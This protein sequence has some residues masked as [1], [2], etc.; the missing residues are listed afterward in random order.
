MVFEFRSQTTDLSAIRILGGEVLYRDMWTMYAPGSIYV[1]A[2]AYALFGVQMVVGNVLGILVSA[3][4]VAALYRLARLVAR[5]V[6]AA[7]VAAIFT[8][9]FLATNY[10]NSLASYP[11]AILFIFVGLERIA[12]HARSGA[13]R[14]LIVAG[15]SLGLGALF[16]HDIVAYACVATA[17]GLV[18]VPV[19]GR[20]EAVWS[21]LVLAGIVVGVM[22]VPLALLLAAGAGRAMVDQLITFPTTY[23]PVVRPEGF[24]VL[25]RLTTNLQVQWR[26]LDLN[27]PSLALLAGLPGVVTG[28]RK[29][30]PEARRVVVMAIFAFLFYWMAAHVQSNTHRVSM[31]AFGPLVGLA[32]LLRYG[33]GYPAPSRARTWALRLV[34]ALWCLAMLMPHVNR[35]Y[36]QGFALEPIGLPRLRGLLASPDEASDLR[37]LASVIAEAGSPDAPLL[38]VGRRNDVLIY[39]GSEPYWLSDRRMVTPYHELHPGVTD[40]ARGQRRMLAEIAEG[41]MPVLVREY[42]FGDEDLDYWGEQYR[43]GGVPVGATLLDEW[44]AANYVPW[45]RIGIYEVMR[46]RS[47]AT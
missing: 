6:P 25:P 7:V 40:I 27:G 47:D 31:A 17:A 21:V 15:L 30:P 29:A 45:R 38:L 14:D 1:M 26:W 9:A 28:W 39:A 32:G 22:L 4:S 13:R 20:R 34:P 10:P 3:A 16:K 43:A 41:P 23:F 2:A 8:F 42:R 24:R 37:A 18:V 11:P 5:P 46:L 44:V 19:K 33:A 12:S 36:R 35:I